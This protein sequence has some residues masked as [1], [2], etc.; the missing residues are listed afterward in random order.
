MVVGAAAAAGAELRM[1]VIGPAARV[2]PM[3]F[4][5]PITKPT[6]SRPTQ[7]GRRAAQPDNPG[8]PTAPDRRRCGGPSS[9]SGSPVAS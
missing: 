7:R 6:A 5:R 4:P 3:S 2:D 9:A 1:A 8:P